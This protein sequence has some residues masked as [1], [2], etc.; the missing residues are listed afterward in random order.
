M[1]DLIHKA[2]HK[3]EGGIEMFRYKALL[4]IF[5]VALMLCVGPMAFASDQCTELYGDSGKKFSLATGSPGELG[6]LSTRS[7]AFLFAGRKRVPETL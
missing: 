6:L 4:G 3:P 5:V 7:M 2:N 1:D